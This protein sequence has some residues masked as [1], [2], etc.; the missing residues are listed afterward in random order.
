MSV[1]AGIA[2]ANGFRVMAAPSSR[3]L[4]SKRLSILPVGQK[5]GDTS[6]SASMVS[7]M[8][9]KILKMSSEN[10]GDS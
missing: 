3:R 1:T 2:C 9:A 6:M 5:G 4:S 10:V 7:Q 8:Y